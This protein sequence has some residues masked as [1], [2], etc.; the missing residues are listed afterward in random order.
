MRH[1]TCGLIS[2]IYHVSLSLVQCN[3]AKLHLPVY[4]E[5]AN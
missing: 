3:V 1:A 5:L 2:A 4:Y